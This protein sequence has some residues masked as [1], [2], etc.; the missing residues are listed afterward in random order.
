MRWI[1]V[2]LA[3]VP[4]L[5]QA[6]ELAPGTIQVT[7]SSNLGFVLGSEKETVAGIQDNKVDTTAFGF[8]VTGLYYVIKDLGVGLDVIYENRSL[9]SPPGD[10]GANKVDSSM[11]QIGPAIEY[12][13]PVAE[14]A[15]VFALGSIGYVTSTDNVT[16]N[17]DKQPAIDKS[18]YGLKLG[19]GA[20]YF[21]AKSFSVDAM[22]G[23]DYRKLTQDVPAAPNPEFTTSGFGVNVGLSVFFGS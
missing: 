21:V 15:S 9:E 6:A 13:Y 5:A 22:L 17:G 11:L 7:G 3:V 1:L 20:R 10:V 2:V 18:G 14:K 19:V 12:D 23:Y 4:M 16:D 8:G